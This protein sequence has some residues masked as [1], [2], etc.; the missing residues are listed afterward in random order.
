VQDLSE[1]TDQLDLEAALART[2]ERHDELLHERAV[3]RRFVTTGAFAAVIVA[4][5]VL[6]PQ[7]GSDDRGQ[8]VRFA[9]PDGSSTVGSAASQDA[10]GAVGDS[11]TPHLPRSSAVPL[12]S[13]DSSEELTTDGEVVFVLTRKPETLP[14]DVKSEVGGVVIAG[15]VQEHRHVE[16]ATDPVPIEGRPDVVLISIVCTAADEELLSVRHRF[17]GDELLIDARVATGPSVARCGVGEAGPSL[18]LPLDRAW[19]PAFTWSAVEL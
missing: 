15:G 3:R 16:L 12:D 9:G 8:V 7:L 18:Q 10:G 11:S 6:L 14:A 2:H 4:A 1:L 5:V 19:D 17:D 13:F